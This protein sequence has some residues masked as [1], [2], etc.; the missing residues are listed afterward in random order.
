L[1]TSV[2]GFVGLGQMGAPMACNV[3]KA[4][5]QVIAFD[6][7]GAAGVVGPAIAGS[8][9]EVARRAPTVFFSLPDG[10]ISHAVLDEIIAVP[11]RQTTI[12]IDLSS[13]GPAAAAEAA[14]RAAAAGITYIDAPVSGGVAGAKAGTLTVMWAGSAEI[15][16]RHRTAVSAIGK[17]IFHVGDKP[18]QA[19]ALKLINNFLSGTAMLATSEAIRCGLKQ[20]LEMKTMLDVLNVSTGMN[21]ATRD[22]FPER[23]L[24][25]TF[26]A[27]FKVK[28]IAKDLALY[29]QCVGEAG[30]SN[31]VGAVVSRI[32][33]SMD[34]VTPE[35]DFTRIFEFIGSPKA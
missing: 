18:G 17:K 11:D 22:K 29:M 15:L 35:A 30:T 28:L 5:C 20:G 8:L 2:L 13:V 9:A 23:I 26:D 21:T 24:T 6:K 34:A 4:G 1:S 3:A 14:A 25:G 33:A 27:G 12:V 31:D 19:Q 16:E 32:W 7:A 10:K